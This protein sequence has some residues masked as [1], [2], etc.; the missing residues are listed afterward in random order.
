MV[1]RSAE[2]PADAAPSRSVYQ[3]RLFPADWYIVLKEYVLEATGADGSV[4]FWGEVGK[5]VTSSADW[6]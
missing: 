2:V 5:A 4:I 6:S 3:I 1:L